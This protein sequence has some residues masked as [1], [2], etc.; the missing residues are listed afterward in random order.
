MGWPTSEGKFST[1][2][3]FVGRIGKGTKRLP[4]HMLVT[5]HF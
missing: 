1:Q 3:A 2:M 5:S 4:K